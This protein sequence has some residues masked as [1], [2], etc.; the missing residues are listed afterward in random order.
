MTTEN[1]SQPQQAPGY[2]KKAVAMGLLLLVAGAVAFH[3]LAG[4]DLASVASERSGKSLRIVT[5]DGA[6][7]LVTL[8][9]VERMPV[10]FRGRSGR[11][12]GLVLLA[13][14]AA[15]ARQLWSYTLVRRHAAPVGANSLGR[16]LGYDG[17]QLW[18]MA[19]RLRLFDLDTREAANA[20]VALE[21]A[22][23][24]LAGLLDSLWKHLV[25]DPKHRRLGFVA[26]DGREYRIDPQT[27]RAVPYSKPAVVM[28]AL[29]D[30]PAAPVFDNAQGFS[31]DEYWARQAEY[32]KQKQAYSRQMEQFNQAQVKALFAKIERTDALTRV[33]PDHD[34]VHGLMVDDQH[35]LGLFTAEEA[36]KHAPGASWSI[37]PKTYGDI[38]RRRFY[39]VTL[40]TNRL[41]TRRGE[42]IRADV[43]VGDIKPLAG[44]ERVW[45]RGGLLRAANAKRALRLSGP[46]SVIV[47]HRDRIDDSGTLRLTRVGFDGA[48]L[49]TVDTGLARITQIFPDTEHVVVTGHPPEPPGQRLTA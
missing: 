38:A 41:L 48:I 26:A 35:W 11:G 44:D 3:M 47:G 49:W 37:P 33:L 16:L 40:A 13:H 10:A 2:G 6:D 7:M 22:N 14:D 28:P 36:G 30:M 27:L 4:S 15:T 9:E 19:P 39:R 31:V 17:R 8:V 21:R 1:G 25:F 18:L 23:P 29:P 45:L 24:Q 43:T 20:V 34:W 32:E 42:L 12:V 5:A 46:D